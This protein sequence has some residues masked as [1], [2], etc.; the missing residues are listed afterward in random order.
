MAVTDDAISKIK[1]MIQQGELRP[2]DRLPPEQELA[3]REETLELSLDA[4]ETAR[5]EIEL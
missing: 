5:L 1:Q 2:G 4:V 3:E